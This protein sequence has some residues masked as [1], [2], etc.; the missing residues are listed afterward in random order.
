[1]SNGEWSCKYLRRFSKSNLGIKYGVDGK[2]LKVNRK[3]I[4]LC[5]NCPN[6]SECL[7]KIRD[8]RALK[9]QQGML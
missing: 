1:M 9:R 5:L 7:E 4:D 2:I 8:D 6:P 3:L